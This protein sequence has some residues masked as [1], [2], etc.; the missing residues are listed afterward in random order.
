MIDVN[1]TWYNSSIIQG[2]DYLEENSLEYFFFFWE[3]YYHEL[4]QSIVLLVL[5]NSV[6]KDE[7]EH[8]QL[9]SM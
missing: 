1:K 5:D 9:Q 7:I 3:L 2:G 8:M 4:I 6:P